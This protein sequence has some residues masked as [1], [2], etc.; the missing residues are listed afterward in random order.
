MRIWGWM[1]LAAGLAA[2]TS[3]GGSAALVQGVRSGF[4]QLE[5]RGQGQVATVAAQ[6]FPLA[7]GAAL[8]GVRLTDPAQGIDWQIPALTLSAPLWAPLDWQADLALPQN[9]LLGG[10][11]FVV[12]GQGAKLDL[13]LGLGRDLPLRG[14]GLALRELSLTGAGAAV[15]SIAVDSVFLRVEPG[16]GA[17]RYEISG[18]AQAI[19]LPP[20][21]AAALSP[22]ALFPDRLDRVSLSASVA[23]EPPLALLARTAPRLTAVDI[24]AGE[25]VWGGYRLGVSGALTVSEAG[26]PE[27][28]LMLAISDWQAWLALA[29]GTGMLRADQMRMLTALAQG[30]AGQSADGVIRLPV[31]FAGGTMFFAGLPIGPA[32]RLR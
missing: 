31:S 20:R 9:L 19:T 10:V 11:P 6:G 25:L 12:A 32:P 26:W 8:Q 13:A 28:T 1:V 3:W 15:S 27:G 22:Q 21:L 30:L 18:Q 2:A 16:N 5:T 14:G 4:A 7:M 24:A 29:R 17:G 23:T